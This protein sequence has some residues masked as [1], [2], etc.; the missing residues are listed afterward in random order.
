MHLNN[1]SS[2]CTIWKCINV[3]VVKLNSTQ[4]WF[5]YLCC[6]PSAVFYITSSC[7]TEHY[8]CIKMLWK[9]YSIMYVSKWK[10]LCKLKYIFITFNDIFFNIIFIIY[11]WSL[12]FGKQFLLYSKYC[13]IVCCCCMYTTFIYKRIQKLNKKHEKVWMT[14]SILKFARLHALLFFNKLVFF[15]KAFW[16]TLH[17]SFYLLYWNTKW[18]KRN[19]EKRL[20]S[21]SN[22]YL[23]F[24]LSSIVT[25]ITINGE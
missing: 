2:L 3:P 19:K 20:L 18:N 17:S 8:I 9:I 1:I 12:P 7:Y 10:M 4:F 14:L 21:W 25:R 24:S 6:F 22:Y 5:P 13:D 15:L 23:S 16:R 11:C